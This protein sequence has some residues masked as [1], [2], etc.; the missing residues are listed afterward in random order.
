MKKKYYNVLN[1]NFTKY[2]HI[3][4]KFFF[5]IWEIYIMFYI[6]LQ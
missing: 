1:N 3:S 5:S 2:E 6:I 4:F